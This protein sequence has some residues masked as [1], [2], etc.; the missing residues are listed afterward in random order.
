MRKLIYLGHQSDC[1]DGHNNG[2]DK[3]ENF[4]HLQLGYLRCVNTNK[5]EPSNR[6]QDNKEHGD[7]VDSLGKSV[8]QCRR[9]YQHHIR[10]PKKQKG[11][12][13]AKTKICCSFFFLNFIHRKSII[14]STVE[15]RYLE[16][17]YLEQLAI[18]NRF[19]SPLVFL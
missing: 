13:K 11:N 2:V 1:S 17:G 14:L 18:S 19:P 12:M 4:G 5:H 16:L 9:N 10:R 15:P 8:I 6:K 3:C 7:Q